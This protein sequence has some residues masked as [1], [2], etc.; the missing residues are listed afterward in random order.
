MKT[1]EQIKILLI[2][3]E[4]ATAQGFPYMTSNIPRADVTEVVE[5]VRAQQKEIEELK[6]LI[7]PTPEVKEETNVTQDHPRQACKDSY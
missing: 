1:P 4:Y 2:N 5:L 7:P 3:L 6:K